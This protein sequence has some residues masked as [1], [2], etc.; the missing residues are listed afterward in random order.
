MAAAVEWTRP[1]Q[2][3]SVSNDGREGIE[4]LVSSTRKWVSS[5]LTEE[6]FDEHTFFRRWSMAACGWEWAKS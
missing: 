2:K 6:K 3:G 1:R 5:T 4:A